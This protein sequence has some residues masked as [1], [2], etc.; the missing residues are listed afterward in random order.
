MHAGAM[1]AHPDMRQESDLAVT[2]DGDALVEAGEERTQAGWGGA[3][4]VR[5]VPHEGEGV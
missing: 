2:G 3:E 4:D 5:E 1:I